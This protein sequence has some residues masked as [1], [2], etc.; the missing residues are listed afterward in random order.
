MLAMRLT[1]AGGLVLIVSQRW[2]VG[3]VNGG[4]VD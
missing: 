2:V 1:V 4:N 3:E